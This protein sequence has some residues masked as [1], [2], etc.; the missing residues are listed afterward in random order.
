MEKL[1]VPIFLISIVLLTAAIQPDTQITA[2]DLDMSNIKDVTDKKKRFF[3]FMRPII[4]AENNKILKLREKL[5]T[6]KQNNSNKRFVAMV[7]KTYSVDWD[8]GNPNWDKLFE[9]VDAV[10][11]ELSLA[12]SAAETACHNP[13]AACVARPGCLRRKYCCQE[14]GQGRDA[15]PWRLIPCLAGARS[16]ETQNGSPGNERTAQHLR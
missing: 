16:G 7:A 14:E 8:E 3:D 13:A 5:Q 2:E 9:R 11:L 12:Q 6:L 4:I 1:L 15:L 10:A